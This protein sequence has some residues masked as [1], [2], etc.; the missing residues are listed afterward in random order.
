MARMSECSVQL[1]GFIGNETID[2]RTT[3]DG[4]P[5]VNL[6][7]SENV[8]VPGDEG[9]EREE[10]TFWHDA[11]ADGALAEKV[12]GKYARQGAYVFIRGVMRYRPVKSVNKDG[13]EYNGR[14]AYVKIREFRLLDAP[15][16]NES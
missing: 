11:V 3:R 1:I 5:I 12:I 15:P 14:E 10:K 16:K 13:K 6:S 2:V 4:T 7:I 9:E 8:S